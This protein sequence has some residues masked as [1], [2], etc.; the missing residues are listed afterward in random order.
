M[1]SKLYHGSPVFGLEYLE[2]RHRYT[3]GAED[4][5]PE[6]IYAS[7][8]AA[9]A[10]AQGFA[11]HSAEG[12]DLGYFTEEETAPMV[13]QVPVNLRQRL[14]QAVSVYT[15]DAASFVVLPSVQP[16]GRTY[17]S[18]E[19]V[20]CEEERRFNSVWEA[21]T[22]CGGQVRIVARPSE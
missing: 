3:P 4:E 22:A 12:I 8:D 10:A 20:K 1:P 9:F 5:S 2:P 16:S 17:R 7:D 18:V 13:L 21:V 6:G 14:D 19:R 11:W 15:L